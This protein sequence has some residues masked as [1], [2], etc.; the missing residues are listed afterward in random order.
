MF[1]VLGVL[2]Y[3]L[4]SLLSFFLIMILVFLFIFIGPI[5]GL[6]AYVAIVH[7]LQREY[8]DNPLTRDSWNVL[9]G[10][11]RMTDVVWTYFDTYG[12]DE[13]GAL[14][15]ASV[16]VMFPGFYLVSHFLLPLT[17]LLPLPF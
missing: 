2:A 9:L 15:I 6:F 14:M 11:R 8:P 17:G 16:V 5:A 3:M 12:L 4:L 1:G 10:T 13:N 7:R